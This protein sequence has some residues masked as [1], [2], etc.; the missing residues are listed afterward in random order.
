MNN[1]YNAFYYYRHQIS[2]LVLVACGF[3]VPTI[4]ILT[5]EENEKADLKVIV[6]PILI[7]LLSVFVIT[8]CRKIILGKLMCYDLDFKMIYELD[9]RKNIPRN[10]YYNLKLLMKVYLYSG[11]FAG[12]LQ[13]SNVVMSSEKDED[14]FFATHMR[15]LAL[16][17][18]G[19]YKDTSLLIDSQKRLLSEMKSIESD[20]Y[21]Q[22][23]SCIESFIH[24]EYNNTICIASNIVSRG[25][26]EKLNH[27][28]ILLF[29]VL[30]MASVQL[31]D[32]DSTLLYSRK[33][34]ECDPK[35]NTFFSWNIQDN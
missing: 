30:K 4:H 15:I 35:R 29:Y 21:S 11:D 26:I 27:R 33:I 3:L 23:Y 20:E 1:N 7:S 14:R 32:A 6:I 31:N 16:F 17:F 34:I 12:V 10:Q 28:K 19:E 24:G 5:L 22:F 13:L 9:K 18:M 25:D 8:S 2:K